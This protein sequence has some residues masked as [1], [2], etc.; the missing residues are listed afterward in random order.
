MRC[1]WVTLSSLLFHT[2]V[3]QLVEAAVSNTVH[4]SVQVRLGVPTS[5]M[6]CSGQKPWFGTKE[7]CVPFGNAA[8]TNPTIPT[9][10]PCDG[11]A[12]VLVLEPGFVGSTPTEG[13]KHRRRKWWTRTPDKRVISRF[14]SCSV[15]QISGCGAVGARQFGELEVVGSSPTTQ[16]IWVVGRAVMQPPFKR[17]HPGT[18]REASYNPWATHQNLG[19]WQNGDAPDS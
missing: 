2:P 6:S 10:C 1:I 15:Y 8:R 13:T 9:M 4:V 7:S 3:A 5:G 18:L 11:T 19:V 14:D 17:T 16:T 12:E